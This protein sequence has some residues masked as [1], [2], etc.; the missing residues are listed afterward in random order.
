MIKSFRLD[1]YFRENENRRSEFEGQNDVFIGELAG[2]DSIAAFKTI[3]DRN[4]AAVIIPVSVYIR[5]EYGN[6]KILEKNVGLLRSLINDN[7]KIREIIELDCADFFDKV[8]LQTM[9]AFQNNYPF[10]SPCPPC[11]FILHFCRIWLA[12]FL[13]IDKIITGE[14]INHDGTKKINQS[15]DLLSFF[16]DFFL[17][18][19]GITLMQPLKLVND[20]KKIDE[21]LGNRWTL[22]DQQLKCAFSGNYRDSAGE[23]IINSKQDWPDIL[24]KFYLPKIRKLKK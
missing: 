21:I 7:A 4:A 16:H 15:A 24:R 6:R 22:K 23:I 13:G 2:R 8:I 19:Y 1:D 9:G 11:H 18:E 10:Y 20:N 12:Q 17:S 14:R 5:S 3:L